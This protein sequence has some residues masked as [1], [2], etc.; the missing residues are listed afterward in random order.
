MAEM[1]EHKSY[2]DLLRLGAAYCVVLMHTAYNGLNFDVSLRTG[3]VGLAAISSFT[4]CAVPLFFMISGSLML[5]GRA[6]VDSLLKKRVPHV[7]VPLLFWSLMHIFW[8]AH[9]GGNWSLSFIWQEMTEALQKPVN[10]SFW[11]LYT[12]IG[13]YLISPFLMMALERCDKKQHML[14]LGL[15]VVLKLRTLAR[16]LWPGFYVS[17]LAFD[18]LDSLDFF[19]GHLCCYILGWYLGKTEKKLPGGVLL[20]AAALTFAAILY[21]TVSRSLPSGAYIQDFQSQSSFFEILLAACLFLLAK[22]TAFNPGGRLAA[23]LEKLAPYSFCVY[24]SH[25]LIL[26]IY[27]FNHGSM[28]LSFTAIVILATAV[29]IIGILLGQLLSCIPLLRYL[30]LGICKG[31]QKRKVSFG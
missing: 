5:D 7:L 28:P 15:V 18:V 27:S 25:A 8:S 1:K 29:Y 4:F 20:L 31:P 12:L 11:F 13:L 10:V 17:Y 22:N 9:T 26:R 2:F 6:D 14:I 16:I 23:V 24:L 19:G 30:S 3:W 21:G